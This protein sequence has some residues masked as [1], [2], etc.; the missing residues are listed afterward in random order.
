M[1]KHYNFSI[2]S[3]YSKK[4]STYFLNENYKKKIEKTYSTVPAVILD[5]VQQ[6]SFLIAIVLLLKSLYN[7][8]NTSEA[9]KILVTNRIKQ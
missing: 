8:G 3:S 5:N 6:D 7:K 2:N 9:I 1:I 4:L